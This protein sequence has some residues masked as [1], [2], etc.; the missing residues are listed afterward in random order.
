MR[1]VDRSGVT[2]GTV[3]LHRDLDRK[4]SQKAR[5]SPLTVRLKR[6][7]QQV[8]PERHPVHPIIRSLGH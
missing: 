8:K 1:S 4:Q 7:Q 5:R 2:P 3:S 6:P